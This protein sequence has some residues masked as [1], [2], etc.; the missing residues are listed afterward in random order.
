MRCNHDNPT[1]RI[2]TCKCCL[3]FGTP[4]ILLNLYGRVGRLRH[5]GDGLSVAQGI[6]K[7]GMALHFQTRICER[8]A[9]G[10]PSGSTINSDQAWNNMDRWVYRLLKYR[11]GK[12]YFLVNY[13]EFL[14]VS[15]Y[16]RSWLPWTRS[17]RRLPVQSGLNLARGCGSPR[18][19]VCYGADSVILSELSL[20]HVVRVFRLALSTRLAELHVN[21]RA[22]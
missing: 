13:E 16:L 14:F 20:V 15:S 18:R 12:R 7:A 21:Q 19:T 17:F 9:A 8:D 4:K 2:E 22:P 3:N 11:E 10:R 1:C 6:L 5:S